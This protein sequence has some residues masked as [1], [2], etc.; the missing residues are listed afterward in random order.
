M[1][2]TVSNGCPTCELIVVEGR[3]A[4]VEFTGHQLSMGAAHGTAEMVRLIAIK[5]V[6]ILPQPGV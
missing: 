2:Q 4:V 5:V 6:S 3:L 1:V